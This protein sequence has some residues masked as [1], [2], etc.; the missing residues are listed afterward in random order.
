M[1]IVST[2]SVIKQM[3]EF[4]QHHSEFDD[5]EIY[6]DDYNFF[7]GV[8]NDEKYYIRQ[9]YWIKISYYFSEKVDPNSH[10]VRNFCH[11]FSLTKYSKGKLQK[12]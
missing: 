4:K 2:I 1:L 3:P 5:E 8:V 9:P 10:K 11:K 6:H 12:L 7:G